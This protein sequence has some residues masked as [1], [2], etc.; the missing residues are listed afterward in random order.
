MVVEGTNLYSC[1]TWTGGMK[2]V[3]FVSHVQ[4]LVWCMSWQLLYTVHD[5]TG[6]RQITY[7]SSTEQFCMSCLQWHLAKFPHWYGGESYADRAGP[8]E[9]LLVCSETLSCT[10]TAVD[11]LCWAMV[12]TGREIATSWDV[13]CFAHRGESQNTYKYGLGMCVCHMMHK[14]NQLTTDG[15]VCTFSV[16]ATSLLSKLLTYMA[17]L[18]WLSV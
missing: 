5:I 12:H 17:N 15:C 13:L 8:L 10:A 6:H 1:S 2:N 4:S 16:L 18:F 3:I 14:V 9:N 11:A 7:W